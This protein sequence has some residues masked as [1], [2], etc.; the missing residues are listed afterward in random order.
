L[1]WQAEAQRKPYTRKSFPTKSQAFLV[2]FL[3]FRFDQDVI[4]GER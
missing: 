1:I 4:S 3:F 2:G